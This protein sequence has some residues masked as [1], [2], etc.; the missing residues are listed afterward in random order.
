MQT[1]L[2]NAL[3]LM[4]L[5]QQDFIDSLDSTST[6]PSVS[7]FAEYIAPY[8]KYEKFC[9]DENG[10]W[11]ATTKYFYDGGWTN[12][13]STSVTGFKL[14]DGSNIRFI[15]QSGNNAASHWCVPPGAAILIGVDVNGAKGPNEGGKDVFSFVIPSNG[16]LYTVGTSELYRYG[17]ARASECR[18]P[19]CSRAKG[20]TTA[21]AY[22][23][24]VEDK[25]IGKF[26]D[27]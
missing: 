2:T 25:K 9:K 8:L 13:N 3:K 21:C 22:K 27:E 14:K 16:K 18:I 5:E 23:F 24:L 4:S 15:A 1:T 7:N 20:I 17:P 26:Y 6:T 11:T 12:Y 10:C 19:R